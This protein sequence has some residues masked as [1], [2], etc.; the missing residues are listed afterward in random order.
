MAVVVT[1][2]LALCLQALG[3]SPA[4]AAGRRPASAHAAAKN[5]QRTLPA[6]HPAGTNRLPNHDISSSAA[7][8][9]SPEHAD[10]ATSL[11]PRQILMILV[12]ECP[13]QQYRDRRSPLKWR[14]A[15]QMPAG[16]R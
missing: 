11:R 1:A 10:P 4:S 2:L 7:V 13:A 9:R 16:T 5:A 14:P 12:L 3:A 8:S 6:A 15:P